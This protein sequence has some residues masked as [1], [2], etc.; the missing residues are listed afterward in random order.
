[1]GK[2]KNE[3]IDSSS[4][5]H[6]QVQG[7]NAEWKQSVPKS[8]RSTFVM[9]NIKAAGVKEERPLSHRLFS[10]TPESSV[11]LHRSPSAAVSQGRGQLSSSC[12]SARSMF[13]RCPTRVTP[14][15]AKSSLVRA[16]R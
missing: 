10:L 13:M 4:S 8:C 12:F 11:C 7:V 5:V 14:S 16:G 2:K 6:C 9:P 3:C 1:M 15:S